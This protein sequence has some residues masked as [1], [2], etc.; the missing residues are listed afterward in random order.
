MRPCRRM[1]RKGRPLLPWLDFG[2]HFV[3]IL[4][5]QGGTILILGW[6]VCTNMQFGS[7]FFAAYYC[8]TVLCST[9]AAENPKNLKKLNP[10]ESLGGPGQRTLRELVDIWPRARKSIT[11]LYYLFC[12]AGSLYYCIIV[13]LYY[14]RQQDSA[15]QRTL[16]RELVDIWPRARKSITITVCITAVLH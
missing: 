8:V 7:A 10:G 3:V 15:G 1:F 14:R 2:L 9:T 13:L 16:R 5:A 12:I 4:G 11:I 6:F